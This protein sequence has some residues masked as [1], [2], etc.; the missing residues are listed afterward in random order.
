MKHGDE[1]RNCQ[2]SLA[3]I[4][5][6]MENCDSAISSLEVMDLDNARSIDVPPAFSLSRS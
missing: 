1:T 3:S 2:N 6:V 5:S 4:S